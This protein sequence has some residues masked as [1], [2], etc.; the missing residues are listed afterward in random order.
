ME[1]LGDKYFLLDWVA[2]VCHRP[3]KTRQLLMYGSPSTQKTLFL[4][5]LSR[6]LQVYRGRSNIPDDWYDLWAIDEFRESD[7]EW[8]SQPG[9]YLA[10]LLRLMDGQKCKCQIFSFLRKEMCLLSFL[11]MSSHGSL[12]KGDRRP[13]EES[14]YIFYR[15]SR[16]S[17][18]LDV[19]EV[20][21]NPG[22][23]PDWQ[24]PH[25]IHYAWI[26]SLER[27]KT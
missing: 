8:G 6:V 10:H 3:V 13:K 1:E 21:R 5:R 19:L 4:T 23:H 11:G 26:H 27:K 17:A 9:G 14:P 25:F 24:P 2:L 16:S 18:D 15:T 12:R 22:G 7:G 20:F